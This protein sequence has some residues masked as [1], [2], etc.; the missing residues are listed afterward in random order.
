MPALSAV[1]LIFTFQFS[2]LFFNISLARPHQHCD[3]LSV[4][5][6]NIGHRTLPKICVGT[7]L[8]WN[9]QHRGKTLNCNHCGVM[10]AW[11]RKTWKFCDQIYADRA[12]NLS[13][14]APHLAHTVPDFIH[15]GSLSAE[16]LPNE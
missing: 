4:L 5:I 6:R 16:L 14:L 13:G 3:V 2:R 12:Q 8:V 9:V 1:L 10:T 15:I 11:S 7:F